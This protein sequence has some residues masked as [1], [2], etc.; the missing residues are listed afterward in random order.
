[1]LIITYHLIVYVLSINVRS[2]FTCCLLA[3]CNLLLLAY[4][5]HINR[6][7]MFICLIGKL[8]TL[9][10][11][12]GLLNFKSLL[13]FNWMYRI[14][15]PLLLVAYLITTLTLTLVRLPMLHH[16][17][18]HVHAAALDNSLSFDLLGY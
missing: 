5:A 6:E 18:Q 15:M 2:A 10:L 12:V 7:Q 3:A 16:S 11:L 14:R 8:E 13:H 9:K 1:M 4:D 17:L